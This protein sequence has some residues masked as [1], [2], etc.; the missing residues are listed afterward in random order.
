V[1]HGAQLIG[2]TFASEQQQVAAENNQDMDS[3]F[4]SSSTRSP[5]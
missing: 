4:G 5:Y 2:R 3:Y 1:V